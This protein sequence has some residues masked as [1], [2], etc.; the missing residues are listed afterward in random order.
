MLLLR[1]A[2]ETVYTKIRE[3][4]YRADMS[5]SYSSM[6]V[7]CYISSTKDLQIALPNESSSSLSHRQISGAEK[8]DEHGSLSG[9]KLHRVPYPSDASY[10]T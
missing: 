2:S 8:A 10:T 6:A 4:T 7:H 5:F 9:S 3:A 1:V